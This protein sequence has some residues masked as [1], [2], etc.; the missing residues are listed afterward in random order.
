MSGLSKI[1]HDCFFVV[2]LDLDYHGR[3]AAQS[4]NFKAVAWDIRTD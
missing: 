1:S 3:E 4:V 2:Q